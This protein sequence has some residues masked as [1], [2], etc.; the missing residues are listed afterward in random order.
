MY[1]EV[2][3]WHCKSFD[4]RLYRNGVELI[5]EKGGLGEMVVKKEEVIGG[6]GVVYFGGGGGD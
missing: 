3:G 5:L 4:G 2:E 6:G 1:D